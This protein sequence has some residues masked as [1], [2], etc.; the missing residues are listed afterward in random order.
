MS[1]WYKKALKYM[2]VT[3]GDMTADEVSVKYEYRL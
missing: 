3:I 1:K 2:M